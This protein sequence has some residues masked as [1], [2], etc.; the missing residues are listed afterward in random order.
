[1]HAPNSGRLIACL[2]VIVVNFKDEKSVGEFEQSIWQ[3]CDSGAMKRYNSE[4]CNKPSLEF[5][6]GR[7]EWDVEEH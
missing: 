4:C 2:G 6:L 1:M 3:E 5:R 7:A